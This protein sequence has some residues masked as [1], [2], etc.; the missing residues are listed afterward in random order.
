MALAAELLERGNSTGC[1]DE[2][3][4]ISEKCFALGDRYNPV[5]FVL[6][7]LVNDYFYG[8][9]SCQVPIIPRAKDP[10]QHGR[11]GQ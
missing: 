8:M 2:R 10:I 3:Q 11:H 4:F 6:L 5:F 1:V 9:P 7:V